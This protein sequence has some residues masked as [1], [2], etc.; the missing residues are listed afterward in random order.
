MLG[1]PSPAQTDSLLAP[2]AYPQLSLVN[3]LYFS[4]ISRTLRSS[5]S[6]NIVAPKTTGRLNTGK[7][8]L[9]K[10]CVGVTG[11]FNQ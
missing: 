4:D 6:E 10:P 3:L 8:I 7:L 1:R 2:V 9:K 5:V 11:G